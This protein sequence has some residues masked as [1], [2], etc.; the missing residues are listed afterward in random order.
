MGQISRTRMT[1]SMTFSRCWRNRRAA[2]QLKAMPSPA[3]GVLGRKAVRKAH[4]GKA[5]KSGKKA[6]DN[7][8]EYP[9]PIARRKRRYPIEQKRPKSARGKKGRTGSSSP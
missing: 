4:V 1:A 7:G 9:S 2:Q 6:R 3:A 8:L 5:A